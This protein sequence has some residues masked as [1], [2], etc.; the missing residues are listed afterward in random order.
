VSDGAQRLP[1]NVAG[2]Y[3]TTE[4]CDGCAY[5]A[6]VAPNH[7]D[8]DKESNTYFV[9]RQPVTP[10][11]DEAVRDAADDCPLDAIQCDA[12]RTTVAA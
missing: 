2:K 11:E 12:R 8:F 3:F 9:T 10:E 1:G 4:D 5:C 6:S 7:F